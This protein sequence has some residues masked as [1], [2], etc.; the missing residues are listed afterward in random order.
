M[1]G[2]REFLESTTIHGLVFIP[3]TKRL[4][5]VFWIFV[6]LIGFTVAGVL[7]QQS[8]ATWARSPISTT[9]ETR[10]IS[11]L[12]FPGVIICPPKKSF[13]SLYPDLVASRNIDFT[14]EKRKEL[15]DF[16]PDAA[17][18]ETFKAKYEEFLEFKRGEKLSHWYTGIS[19]MGVP[20]VSSSYK[21]YLL[22]TSALNGSFST[23]YFGKPFDDNQFE[24]RYRT[25]VFLYVP[26]NLAVGTKLIIDIYYDMGDEEENE[27]WKPLVIYLEE[28]KETGSFY[29]SLIMS[30]SEVLDKTKKYIRREYNVA[31]DS[32][33]AV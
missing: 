1:E 7:I 12:D 27:S 23:P 16:V 26:D 10:P 14:Q 29:F 11:E 31:E 15:S 18:D 2:I 24:C 17:Y 19:L 3:T 25:Q 4:V 33:E 32:A 21:R 13:T 30:T 5:Q 9:I 22:L 28:E 8:F 6:V 20:Y